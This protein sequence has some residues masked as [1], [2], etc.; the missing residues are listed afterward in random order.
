MNETSQRHYS[1]GQFRLNLPDR[2]LTR[3]GVAVSLPPKAF[4]LLA[5]LVES[6]GH[7]VDKARII[8]TLW[9]DTFVEEANVPNLIGLLRKTLGDSSKEPKYI[10]TVPKLG[11]RFV[12][13]LS[14]LERKPRECTAGPG[15]AKIRIIAFPFRSDPYG[16]GASYL[17]Y[18]LPE[19][20]AATLAELNAFTVRSTQLA[21][22]F[23]PLV[24]DPKSVA[25]EADVDVILTGA[26]ARTEDR[27]HVTTELIDARGSTVLWS[28]VWVIS[29]RDLHRLHSGVVQLIVRS[30][31]RGAREDD[32]A[33]IRSLDVPSAPSAYEYYLRANQLALKRTPENMALARDLYVA[34]TEVDPNYAPAWARLGRCYHW[35]G[36]FSAQAIG[37]S[38]ALTEAAFQRAFQLNPQLSI[39]HSAYTPFEADLGRAQQ[40]MIRLL[41]TLEWS[42]SNAEIFAALVHACRYCGQLGA[43]ITA[44]ERAFRL[45]RHRHT[46]V[47]HTYFA[48]GDYEKALHWYGTSGGLY[49]DVLALASMDRLDEAS[50]LLWTRR[51]RFSMASVLM[52]SLECYLNGDPA[53]GLAALR[54]ELSSCSQ[55][56][57]A[58]FYMARQAAR[59]G[60]VD[61]AHEL[62]AKS[63]E[64][65]YCASVALKHDPWL[66]SLRATPAFERLLSLV[67]ARESV[68]L[69]AF[70]EAGGERLLSRGQT[71][72]P[73]LRA[74]SR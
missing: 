54:G 13:A 72:A 8:Q 18:S 63:A 4:D 40:A 64:R 26:L 42:E 29:V 22:R 23:D 46:S 33:S 56:P 67:L 3:N 24:W 74:A 55:D 2:L 30:L 62:V 21:T 60:D 57:E 36:K 17:A 6:A 9:P 65:G 51:D 61:L 68:A 59:F 71:L 7:L 48:L 50:S 69:D 32:E 66:E 20:I 10:Q 28:K 39:A 15:L 38:A 1:F 16:A 19:A 27:I 49:L 34:S 25:A 14:P 12:A 47:A 58:W 43:S 37:S 52:R 73:Q 53:G 45:D 41:K 31:V 70:E 5:L 44:H 35:L 11:Y